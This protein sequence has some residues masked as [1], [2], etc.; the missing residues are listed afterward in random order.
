MKFQ[1]KIF[2]VIEYEAILRLLYFNR[3]SGYAIRG[4]TRNWTI[5]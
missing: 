5:T 1:A 2:T 4:I 3:G